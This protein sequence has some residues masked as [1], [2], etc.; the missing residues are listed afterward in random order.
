M[1]RPSIAAVIHTLDE[2]PRVAFALRSVRAWVDDVVVV[3]MESTDRTAE[4]ASALGARVFRHPRTGFVEPARA[5]GCERALGDWIL[6]LDADEVVPIR[7]ARRLRE[8]A[9]RGEVDAVRIPRVNYILGATV[10]HSG[11][12]PERDRHLRFWRRG[13]V[14]LPEEIHGGAT[15]LPGRRLLELRYVAGEAIAHLSH[16]DVAGFLHKLN[17]YTGVEAM[18]A[19]RRG[20]RPSLARAL[21]ASAREWAVRYLWHGGFR[22][23]WRGFYLALFMAGYRLATEAKIAEHASSGGREAVEHLY[24]REAEGL[25][26]A[27]EAPEPRRADEP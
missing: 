1:R 13:A 2:E 27:H 6:V 19:E 23:G 8:V 12:N 17:L 16:A 11:W 10:L 15:V 7:L 21:V 3:D 5:F 18:Q 24:A 25:L 9:E 4:I 20:T 14:A 22:D 26:A